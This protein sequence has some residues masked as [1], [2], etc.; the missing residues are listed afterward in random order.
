MVIEMDRA[1]QYVQLY[2]EKTGQRLTVTHLVARATAAALRAC[3]DANAILRFDRIYLRQRIAV[4]MQVVMS[5]EGSENEGKVDLSGVTIHD[6]ADKDLS[7]IVREVEEKVAAVRARKDAALERSRNMF[8]VIPWFLT[9]GVLRL[10]SFLS[11]S[12]NLDLRRLGI[13]QDAFGSVMITNVGSLGLDVAYAPLV[14]YARV[15]MVLAMGAVKEQPA[16]CQGQVVVRNQMKINVTFDHR[17]I[18][19]FHAAIM[20][21]VV[22]QWLEDPEKHFGPIESTSG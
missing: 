11:Y 9:H 4:F 14:P 17:F 1:L 20:S 16:V 2:R 12:L 8:S 21:K 3:P 7:E 6:A 19:G 22:R 15:P 10:V 13:P 18:D 5:E